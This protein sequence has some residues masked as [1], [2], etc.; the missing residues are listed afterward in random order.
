MRSQLRRLFTSDSRASLA[1]ECS[2]SA[3]ATGLNILPAASFSFELARRALLT[4]ITTGLLLVTTAAT[5]GFALAVAVCAV[6]CPLGAAAG[7]LA[8]VSTTPVAV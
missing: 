3:I 5:A 2:H 7:P 1:L 4:L 6:P 8:T